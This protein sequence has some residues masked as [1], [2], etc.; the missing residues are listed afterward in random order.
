MLGVRASELALLVSG[1]PKAD[2]LHVELERRRGRNLARPFLSV[3]IFGRKG[4]QR[5][6][7][8]SHRGK[9]AVPSADD[10]R[11]FSPGEIKS[12]WE[13]PSR[14]VHGVWGVYGVWRTWP[15]P[16]VNSN[17]WSRSREESKMGPSSSCEASPPGVENTRPVYLRWRVAGAWQVAR[18]AVATTEAAWWQ[19]TERVSSSPS[20][21]SRHVLR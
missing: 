4:E 16:S 19:R 12:I 9:P 2:Q 13:A 14:G 8:H 1:G 6:L 3:G 15:W 17:G 7:T 21:A 5:A 11:A 10:L 20:V 18:Q